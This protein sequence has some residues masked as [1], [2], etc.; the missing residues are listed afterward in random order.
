MV[1]SMVGDAPEEDKTLGEEN[2]K[3][4]IVASLT[5]RFYDEL[6]LCLLF[7]FIEGN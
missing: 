5:S 4:K 6:Y 2:K 1:H 3:V 7:V